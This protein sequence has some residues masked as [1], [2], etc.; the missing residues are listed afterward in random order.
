[1]ENIKS[2][3]ITD[4]ITVAADFCRL[5]EQASKKRTGELFS[6]LQLVLPEIYTKASTLQKPKYC[7]EEE[8][9]KFVRED[10]YAAIHD[11]LQQKIELVNGIARMSP[12]TRPTQHELVSFSLAELLADIYEELKNFVMLY[13]VAIPQAMNDAVWLC[14]ESFEQGFGIKLIEALKLLHTVIYNKDI[15]GSRAVKID[16]FEQPLADDEDEPWYSDEQEEVYGDDE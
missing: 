10:D 3:A 2:Q 14:R 15:E 16:D 13:E 12:G 7:Y 8:P 9:K 1:M 11:A 6:S 4:F 5:I